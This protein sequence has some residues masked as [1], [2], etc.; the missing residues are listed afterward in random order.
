MYQTYILGDKTEMVVCE[1]NAVILPSGAR[2]C[3]G[4]IACHH[5]WP[6]PLGP[7]PTPPRQPASQPARPPAQVIKIRKRSLSGKFAL[8][9][10][11]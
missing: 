2:Y 1:K 7:H 11:T 8:M 9:V 10:E 4:M 6:Q 5:Q 3:W